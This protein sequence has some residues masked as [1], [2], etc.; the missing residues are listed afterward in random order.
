[1]FSLAVALMATMTVSAQE[2]SD[3]MSATLIHG[4]QTSVYYTDDALKTALENSADGD[5]IILSPG[6][7]AGSSS[8]VDISKSVSI[9]GSGFDTEVNAS[10]RINEVQAHDAYGKEYYYYPTVK[11]EGITTSTIYKTSKTDT[12]VLNNLQVRKC[13]IK[14][15]YIFNADTKDCKFS[16]CVFSGSTSAYSR[17][18]QGMVYENCYFSNSIPSMGDHTNNI[19]FDHCIINNSSVS[20][21]CVATYTNCIIRSSIPEYSVA[22]NNIFITTSA[23]GANVVGDNNWFNIDVTGIYAADGEDGSYSDDKDFAL[24]YPE[25]YVGTDGT[26]VGINGGYG[27][28]RIPAIPRI[29][30]SEI[31]TR[32]SAD[33]KINVSISVE[34]Q[35][36]E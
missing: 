9:Y 6:S 18:H 8:G 13:K 23:L 33:G 26:E 14:G 25:T 3:I 35:T 2:E 36:K 12:T 29:L 21:R 1:M 27:F 15:S 17:N 11:I 5:V 34:A 4:D 7:F 16:Q 32:S 31:D 24:K 22:Y 10:I 28:S 30:S 20:S 19:L